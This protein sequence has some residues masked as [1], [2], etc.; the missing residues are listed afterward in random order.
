MPDVMALARQLTPQARGRAAG[1]PAAEAPRRRARRARAARGLGLE[2]A[3]RSRR[4]GAGAVGRRCGGAARGAIR[5]LTGALVAGAPRA[6]CEARERESARA[7]E[8]ESARARERGRGARVW[9]ARLPCARGYPPAVLLREA[10]C[11]AGASRAAVRRSMCTR[12]RSA[13]SHRRADTPWRAARR[14]WRRAEA[15]LVPFEAASIDIEP[16][17]AVA[18]R[19]RLAS[20]SPQLPRRRRPRPADRAEEGGARSRNACASAAAA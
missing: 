6:R 13:Q 3:R 8:R 14:A 10:P 11:F 12:D 19:S 15:A 7:R 2:A 5:R 20:T 16:G 1:E 17:R 4:A 9:I 18:R